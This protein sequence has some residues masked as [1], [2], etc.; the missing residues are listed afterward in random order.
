MGEPYAILN[1]CT[2]NLEGVEST[3]QGMLSP[4]RMLGFKGLHPHPHQTCWNVRRH[5]VKGGCLTLNPRGLTLK[6]RMGCGEAIP[7]L[8]HFSL[9]LNTNHLTVQQLTQNPSPLNR[10]LFLVGWRTHIC[11]FE[12]LL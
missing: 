5:C 4:S 10:T 8:P 1:G 9:T 12:C 11:V 3:Y 6:L 2:P 7:P